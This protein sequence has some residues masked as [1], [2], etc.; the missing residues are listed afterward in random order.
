MVMDPALKRRA[1]RFVLLTVLIYS[2]GFGIIMPVLPDLI[3]HLAQVDA[4]EA[5]RIGAWIGA[6]YG[7]FQ[8][9]LM[10]AVGNLGD[11]FGRRPIF[12]ISLFAFGFDF[13]LMG[14][15][16][17][18]GW[19]FVGRAIAGG[20][21]AVFG[22]A[23]AAM[24]DMSTPEERA[25]S[26]GKVGAAFGLGFIFGPVIGGLLGDF[27]PR[28]P[29]YVA[30]ALA[31]ANGIYGWI[32]FP[33]TMPEEKRRPFEWKRANPLGAFA[34]LGKIE[35]IVPVAL[36]Y[37]L[38][39]LAGNV[40]PASWSFFAPIQYGWGSGMVG[41]SL[42]LVGISMAVFQALV[43]RRF[44]TRFGE[45]KT[46]YIG[47]ISGI[48][49]YL[50]VAFVPFAGIILVLLLVNGFSG[51][52]MPALNAMMSQRA[53]ASQQ[54][55]LQGLVGSLAAFSLMIGQ[56]AYNYALAAF[57]EAGAPIRF[58]GAPYLIAATAGLAALVALA[59]LRKRQLPEAM[60]DA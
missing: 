50:I 59:M 29:F 44:I 54:G 58:P 37:F 36:I 41:V 46:A 7:L 40:Y 6:T 12:L 15:A 45:R 43:I 24:A 4:A 13:L 5:A 53:P 10:P 39:S 30:G 22:P 56:F 31:I 52:V 38:W 18:I 25:A 16:P 20:L 23:N 27:G 35:G 34:S 47:M 51:M 55:E 57:T 26:F 14:L 1:S 28:V 11:R 9:L 21:G 60:P 2:M 48:T 8:I 49:S 33:E 17:N 32:V 19:L 3:K 42:G